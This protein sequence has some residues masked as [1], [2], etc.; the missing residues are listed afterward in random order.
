MKTKN[1]TDSGSINNFRNWL[2]PFLFTIVISFGI[3]TVANATVVVTPATGGTNVS[4]D[5]AA[6]SSNPI[7]GT[8]VPLSPIKI[9][10][11]AGTD[12]AP[13]QSGVTFILTAPA[14]WSFNT[15]VGTINST[16]HG[17]FSVTPSITGRTSNT[18]TVTFST[19]SNTS[20]KDT[21]TITGLQVKANDGSII[22]L[23]GNI[24]RT[25]TANMN[26]FTSL[27][28]CGSLSQVP[29]ALDHFTFKT[30][31]TQIVGIAFPD[32]MYAK[33]Q[34]A[35][36]ITG[37][38][39][40]ANLSINAG[41]TISPIAT[42]NFIGGVKTLNVT[43][44][45]ATGPGKA[46]TATYSGHTGT[47]NTFQLNAA[48]SF[49]KLQVLLP[50]EIAAPNTQSGKTGTPTHQTAGT[51]FTITVN[52]VDANWNVVSSTD[53]IHITSSDVN[54]TPVNDAA[55]VAGTKTFNVTLNTPGSKTVTA[56]DAD[57]NTKTPNT[58]SAVTVNYTVPTVTYLSQSC[59][60]NGDDNLTITISGTNF[61][62]ASGAAFDG[63]SIA[64]VYVNSTHLTATIISSDLLTSGYHT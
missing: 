56:S 45:G 13:N 4:A 47:S 10:E 63:A 38:T 36:T 59:V 58:S 34:F 21:I 1:S 20:A 8:W 11:A 24:T 41:N 27:T 54:M 14:N 48:S 28:N 62:P 7:G 32:T 57:N 53:N 46:I 23:S 49:T 15:G 16:N 64:T 30:I 61:Y 50:G 37:F 26:G 29:G 55:L 25:G 43:V 35:T 51:P 39:S 33:D 22:P 17:S 5:K 31:G 44:T 18:I 12:F 6:N 42:G 2:M 60:I 40:S 19:G 52:A 9:A 3:N